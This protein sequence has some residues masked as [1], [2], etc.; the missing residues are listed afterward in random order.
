MANKEALR[1]LQSRLAERLK[2]AQTQERGRSWLAVECAGHG[3]LFPLQEAGEIFPYAPA[4]PVPYTSRW[5]L[6]VAN[7][8]GRLH[9]V[10]DLAG[11]LGIRGNEQV[12]DQSWFVAFNAT[13]NINCAVMVDRLSGLRS[14]EQ[15]RPDVDD[16]QAKPGFVGA[17]YR[18]ENN[19]L[20]RELNLAAL[21]NESAFLKIAG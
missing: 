21:A 16:G 14:L 8:R 18:D 19:R 5:F 10:V 2:V 20:W 1:E 17:P 7:L 6:G 4:M 13:T 15:L 3:F 11:F 12:R 9:G